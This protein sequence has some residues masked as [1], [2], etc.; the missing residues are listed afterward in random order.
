MQFQCKNCIDNAQTRSSAKEIRSAYFAVAK[1][2]LLDVFFLCANAKNAMTR[3]KTGRERFL[4]VE[5]PPLTVELVV[6]VCVP[7]LTEGTTEFVKLIRQDPVRHLHRETKSGPNS[8]I[9]LWK[10]SLK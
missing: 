10:N 1:D 4:T 5:V 3:G 9:D 8:S 6:D 7:R 2:I